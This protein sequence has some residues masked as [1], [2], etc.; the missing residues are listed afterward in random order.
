MNR[1]PSPLFISMIM[2]A[3]AVIFS[4]L[5]GFVL[6]TLL[7]IITTV[8]IFIYQFA[9]KKPINVAT[10]EIKPTISPFFDMASCLYKI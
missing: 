10:T 8:N 3:L 2:I 6:V 4:N 1:K 5:H 9:N 7:L